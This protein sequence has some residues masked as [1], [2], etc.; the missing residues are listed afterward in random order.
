M[1]K[2]KVTVLSLV[3]IILWCFSANA[4]VVVDVNQGHVNPLPIALTNFSGSRQDM[5]SGGSVEDL[6]IRITQVIS[7][8]LERSGLFRVIDQK[9]FI[10][11]ANQADRPQFANWSAIGAQALVTGALE[12]FNVGNI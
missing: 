1:R 9:A 3:G 10:N 6:G 2:L 7:A 11:S 8:D 12:L 5:V 4:I